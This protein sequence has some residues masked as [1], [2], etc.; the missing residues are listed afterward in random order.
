MLAFGNGTELLFG[1]MYTH[2]R[3]RNTL[4]NKDIG[5]PTYY[6]NDISVR[7]D[8]TSWIMSSPPQM[9]VRQFSLPYFELPFLTI[10]RHSPPNMRTSDEEEGEG[11]LETV[12]ETVLGIGIGLG[13]VCK[14][15]IQFSMGGMGNQT[16]MT[17]CIPQG[18]HRGN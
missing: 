4:K 14:S 1:R 13:K 8:K 2:G 7:A 16:E 9:A 12:L 18:I 11:V 5:K 17:I 15:P 10:V 3:G 6:H